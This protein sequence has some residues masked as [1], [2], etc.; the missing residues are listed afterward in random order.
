MLNL[1]TYT[2]SSALLDA[3]P[4]LLILTQIPLN[5]IIGFDF[6]TITDVLDSTRLMYFSLK[7]FKDAQEAVKQ[8]LE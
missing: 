6:Y 2:L 4:L 7:P 3:N 1:D 5:S 8:L